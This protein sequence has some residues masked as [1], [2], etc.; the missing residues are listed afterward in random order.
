LFVKEENINATIELGRFQDDTTIKDAISVRSDLIGQADKVL[1]FILKHIKKEYA[2]TG[3]LKRDEIWEYPLD[4]LREIV[5]N[6]IVHRDYMH[7]G[8]SSV[9]IFDDRIE[10]YNPGQLTEGITIVDLLKGAYVSDCRNKLIAFAFKE[11]GW[12]EKY[13]SGMIKIC[14]KHREGKFVKSYDKK[15]LKPNEGII[16]EIRLPC[17]EERPYQG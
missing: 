4:A 1:G 5:L 8:D 12:I 15:S 2:I 11:I 16:R 10:F 14:L 17:R 7:H 13:G 9:K 6:M 3:K